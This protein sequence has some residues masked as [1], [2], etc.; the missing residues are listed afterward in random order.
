MLSTLFVAKIASTVIAVLGLSAIAERVG[1]A[2]AGVLAGVPLGLAIIFFFVGIQHGPEFVARSAPYALGGLAATL[3]FNLAYW[4]VSSLVSR[5]RFPISA[6]SAMIAFVLAAFL[7][8][9][10][11]L[12]DR[13]GAALVA[14]LAVVT[15]LAMR[16]VPNTEINTRVK[17]TWTIIGLRAGLAVAVVLAITEAAAFI[18]PQW[19]GLLTGFP[20][21]LFPVLVIIHFNYSPEDAH[22]L[23]KGFPL[24]IPSLVI[25]VLC[26]QYLYVPLG[27]PLGFACSMAASIIW[28]AGYFGV[29]HYFSGAKGRQRV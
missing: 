15:V 16:S 18:G 23:L 7:I 4:R 25:F 1:P 19:A 10:V 28:L 24:G 20:I 27:V 2:L 29:K 6:A 17:M 11:E 13:T 5:L 21:T 9:R 12:T 14:V 22:T 26:S 8:S 3:C